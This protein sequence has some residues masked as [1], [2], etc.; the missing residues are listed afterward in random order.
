[1]RIETQS[2]DN[3]HQESRIGPIGSSVL[4]I[5]RGATLLQASANEALQQARVGQWRP[6]EVPPLIVGADP[7]RQTSVQRAPNRPSG[8]RQA[9]VQDDHLDRP[10]YP[11]RPADQFAPVPTSF[12]SRQLPLYSTAAA[13]AAAGRQ[14]SS[15]ELGAN[16]SRAPQTGN[17]F[18]HSWPWSSPQAPALALSSLDYGSADKAARALKILN[19]FTT[20]DEQEQR[21][22]QTTHGLL[23]EPEAAWPEEA[24]RQPQ[25][26]Q[27]LLLLFVLLIFINLI[28]IL[29][30][31]LVIVA[32]YASAKL[33][34]V[35]NIFIVSLATA[36][37]LLGILVLPYALVY[38][39]SLLFFS[40]LHDSAS[41]YSFSSCMNP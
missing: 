25:T 33:R 16:W 11:M 2:A 26:S 12:S 23:V 24:N 18:T 3:R 37:L 6:E 32:V 10:L 19:N 7:S 35:T 34:S 30:N 38:E 22:N 36:D 14:S 21:I 20:S 41:S 9:L 29:G 27:L 17:D 15:H 1:M 39:V 28:V 13:P 5:L 40:N 4:S 31:I 8:R